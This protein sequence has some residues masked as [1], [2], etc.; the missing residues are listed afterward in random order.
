MAQ[1]REELTAN[2][3]ERWCWQVARRDDA[4]VARRLYRKPVVDGGLP[5]GRGRVAG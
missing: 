5:A 1:T 4:R 2:L 3:A